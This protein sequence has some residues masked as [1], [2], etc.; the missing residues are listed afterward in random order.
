MPYTPRT[1]GPDAAELEKIDPATHQPRPH[2][3]RTA[4]EAEWSY[5][6][7]VT[8]LHD[9]AEY[10]PLGLEVAQPRFSWALETS[11]R[12]IRQTAYRIREGWSHALAL[13]GPCNTVW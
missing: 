3:Y 1:Y 10:R 5:E 9:L 6:H 13:S 7:G 12:D 11:G 2:V 8:K 4:Q